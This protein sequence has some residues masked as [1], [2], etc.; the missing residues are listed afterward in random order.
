MKLNLNKEQEKIISS[1]MD[2]VE[3]R[4]QTK[5]EIKSSVYVVLDTLYDLFSYDYYK[6]IAE[7]VEKRIDKKYEVTII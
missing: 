7:E 4:C 3:E 2:S 1:I 5:E 6:I